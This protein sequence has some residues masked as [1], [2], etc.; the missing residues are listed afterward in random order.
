MALTLD[1]MNEFLRAHAFS[2]ATRRSYRHIITSFLTDV[3]QHPAKG[4]PLASVTWFEGLRLA[5]NSKRF[6]LSVVKSFISWCIRKKYIKEGPLDGI[7][8]RG[9]SVSLRH[10]LTRNQVR[11][12]LSDIA[13]DDDVRSRR[14]YAIIVFMLFTGMRISSVAGINLND[15]EF[16]GDEMIVKYKSK[17]HIG[18]DSFSVVPKKVIG[19]IERYLEARPGRANI[20]GKGPLFATMTKPIRRLSA[21]GLR[22]IIKDRFERAG[23]VAK[24][25]C[26]HSLRHTAAITAFEN[27]A[28][29]M[30]VKDMLGHKNVNTTMIYLQSLERIGRAAESK[31]DYG[32]DIQGKNTK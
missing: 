32:L 15:F 19:I 22:F 14:D 9:S 28:D 25:I 17:G 7:K 4:W 26:P 27:G 11:D 18:K 31:I 20:G 6:Y 13:M 16:M 1:H 10:A 21:H 5:P 12:L 3:K 29:I 23:I 8:I 30:A 2:K 24:G